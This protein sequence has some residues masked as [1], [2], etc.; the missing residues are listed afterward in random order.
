MWTARATVALDLALAM[1]LAV[2]L[3]KTHSRTYMHANRSS[4][5][6]IDNACMFGIASEYVRK[7]GVVTCITFPV[8]LLIA[9]CVKTRNLQSKESRIQNPT[10]GIIQ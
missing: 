5:C 7:R 1:V 10:Y 4:M 8:I 9:S 6:D 3:K 2:G